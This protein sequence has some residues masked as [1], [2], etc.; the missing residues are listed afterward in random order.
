MRFHHALGFIAVTAALGCGSSPREPQMPAPGTPVLRI[1]TYNVNYGIAGDPSTLETIADEDADAVFIQEST[2]P[3][4]QA[5][6]QR[7]GDRYPH[8]AFHHCCGAGGLGVLSKHPF[9]TPHVLKPPDGGWFP[10]WHLVLQGPIGPLQVLNVHLR[11]AV[12]DGGSVVS[13]YFS[14]PPIRARQIE[15]FYAA[16]DPEMPTL[17]LGDFNEGDGGRAIEFLREKGFRS[18]LSE[19]DVPQKTWHWPTSI[20]TVSAQLDHIV[21]DDRLD[22][23]DVHVLYRGRSDHFP[24][25]G[26]FRTAQPPARLP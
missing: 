11:P 16:L 21:Y 25:V 26:V 13:G 9:S 5:L 3:W 10:A 1:M 8:I 4:E 7:L 2:E 23:L 14:T 15:Y 24:V 20:G 17:I 18:A 19:F 12:S 22:P 6:R